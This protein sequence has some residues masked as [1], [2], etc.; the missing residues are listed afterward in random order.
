M[1]LQALQH[2]LN[3][4]TQIMSVVWRLNVFYA[5]KQTDEE[6]TAKRKLSPT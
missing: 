4:R 6:G 3:Q 1:A 2:L 5:V